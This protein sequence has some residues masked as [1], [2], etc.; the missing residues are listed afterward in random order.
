MRCWWFV[1]FAACGRVGF[2]P[3]STGDGSMMT[4]DGAAD[5]VVFEPCGAFGE[6]RGEFRFASSKLMS[7]KGR[8]AATSYGLAVAALDGVDLTQS[9]FRFDS[10]F[11]PIGSPTLLTVGN[12]A[13]AYDP[14]AEELYTQT[15][16]RDPAEYAAYSA[17]DGQP[18]RGPVFGNANTG[19]GFVDVGGNL[20]VVHRGTG[21]TQQFDASLNFLQT[22]G[23]TAMS[24][25]DVT[26]DRARNIAWHISVIGTVRAFDTSQQLRPE[27]G[28]FVIP[29]T[30]DL[31]ITS[32]RVDT[33]Y[34]LH[35]TTNT[36][37]A[38]REDGTLAD[39]IVLDGQGAQAFDVEYDPS[40]GWLVVSFQD[41]PARMSWLRIVC[42]LP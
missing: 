17:I 41:T 29:Q 35:T 27:L 12:I 32:N 14:I 11:A 7:D 1:A 3:M 30:G 40:R 9:L 15:T 42:G 18:R 38:Y 4:G 8:I 22:W 23:T 34:I 20:N 5:T 31:G 33:L 16:A 10:L 39:S 24:G 36:L 25:S 28:S 2:D 19:A 21:G 13:L 6:S 37:S 26:F